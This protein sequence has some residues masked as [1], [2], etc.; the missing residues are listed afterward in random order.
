[1]PLAS[2]VSVERCRKPDGLAF[3]EAG[4]WRVA[5]AFRKVLFTVQC[6]WVA[7]KMAPLGH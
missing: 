5:K 2:A 3:M 7:I 4:N 6:W 1:M